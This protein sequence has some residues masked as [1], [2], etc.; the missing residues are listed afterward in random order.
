[1]EVPELA[2]VQHRNRAG[3]VEYRLVCPREPVVARGKGYIKRLGVLYCL[4]LEWRRENRA[5]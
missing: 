5:D 3:R 4:V 2:S 1:M